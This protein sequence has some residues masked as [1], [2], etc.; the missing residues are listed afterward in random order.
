M[1]VF[2]GAGAPGSDTAVAVDDVAVV[3]VVAGASALSHRRFLLALL[4]L[5]A[6]VAAA[7]DG[8]DVSR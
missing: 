7:G 1:A 6:V 3:G 5:A 2:A 8:A 4:S